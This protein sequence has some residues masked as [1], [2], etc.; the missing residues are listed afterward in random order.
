MDSSEGQQ[1]RALKERTTF[2]CLIL[3]IVNRQMCIS[4]ED[5]EQVKAV[6]FAIL[7]VIAACAPFP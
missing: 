6:I 2:S 4:T 5:Y 7:C 1:K 3:W